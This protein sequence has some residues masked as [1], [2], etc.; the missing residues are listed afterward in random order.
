M[1]FCYFVSGTRGSGKG[2]YSVK[3]MVDTL[4]NSAPVATNI[5]LYL[6]HLPFMLSEPLVT[7]LSDIP[8][9]QELFALGP[10]YDMTDGIKPEKEGVIVLDEISLFLGTN[11]SKDFPELMRFFMLSRKLGWNLVFILQSKDQANDTFYKSLCNKLVICLDNSLFKIPYITK[12]LDSIGL[13][14][15]FDRGHTAHIFKGRSELDDLD[16]TV[17]YSNIPYRKLYNTNQLFEDGREYI[18]N[19]FID[20]RAS[21]TLVPPYWT[22][23]Q[24][25]I[26]YHQEQILK[27]SNKDNETMAIKSNGLKAGQF[28]KIGLMILFLVVFLYFNNPMDNPLIADTVDAPVQQ[29]LPAYTPPTISQITPNNGDYDFIRNLL[30]TYKPRLAAHT[31]S[32]THGVSLIIDF[33]QGSDLY[34][35]LVLSDFHRNGY[36]VTPSGSN[37]VIVSNGEYKKRVSAWILPEQE[38]KPTPIL[39]ESSTIF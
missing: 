36:S 21:Y 11:K 6:E 27:L 25:F 38:V 9:S 8:T 19:A 37:A 34:E 22:T 2:V 1:A 13:A 10:A 12:I 15:L 18:N 4:K 29:A 28:V 24:K 16:G 31:T 26:D 14:E 32:D 20:M 33:Y 23:K 5:D 7:R 35:R 30:D 39:A 3:M 17:D